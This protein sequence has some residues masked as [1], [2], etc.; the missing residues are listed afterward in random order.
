MILPTSLSPSSR[1]RAY[2]GARLSLLGV[3][4]LASQTHLLRQAQDRL[5]VRHARQSLCVLDS[6]RLM[7][8]S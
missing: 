5:T 2:F 4:I 6:Y 8:A 1:F 3:A 7:L